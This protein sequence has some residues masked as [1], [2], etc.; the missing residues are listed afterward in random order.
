MTAKNSTSTNR[1]EGDGSAANSQRKM[2]DIWSGFSVGSFKPWSRSATSGV[3]G[4][5]R[6]RMGFATGSA[7]GCCSDS[8]KPGGNYRTLTVTELE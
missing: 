4:P 6:I 8:P 5:N 1:P 2:N 7:T 3:N